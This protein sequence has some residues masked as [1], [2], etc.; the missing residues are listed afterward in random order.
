[1][2][3][4]P[5]IVLLAAATAAS[6]GHGRVVRVE[7]PALRV[8][9]VPGG[10]FA[11][12]MIESD[13]AAVLLACI[14]LHGDNRERKIVPICF[15]A[16]EMFEAM[17]I[18]DVSVSTFAIDRYEVT[19][20]EYR[21]CVHAGGCGID[22]LIAGDERYVADHALPIV[23]VTWSEARTFCAWRDGRLP[24]EAEWEK[25]ARGTDGRLWPWGDRER[26]DDFN[27]GRVPAAANAAVDDLDVR[28][29]AV[30]ANS[31]HA[32][33]TDFG[34]VDATDGHRYAAPPGSYVW[35]EGPFGTFDQAGNVAEW[36][37]DEATKDG[38]DLLPTTNPVRGANSGAVVARVIRGGSWRDPPVF[39]M[40]AV[41]API[42][43]AIKGDER[44][45]HVG[46]RCAYDR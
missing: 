44:Y 34:E 46:F 26:P 3:W 4:S 43:L 28:N 35:G 27:H 10:K 18:R 22:P 30:G 38:Y 6:A 19:V 42:N 24:T 25:A 1:M 11:M 37:V 15:S 13:T 21:V 16:S 32:T 33:S 20:A 31:Y 12:G 2:R 40:T 36:V 9:E 7:R 39:A 45:P 23:N 41:R 29:R 5:A 17:A 8:V 14:S